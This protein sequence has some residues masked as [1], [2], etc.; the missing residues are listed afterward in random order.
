[1]SRNLATLIGFAAILLWAS[2][3]GLLKQVSAVLEPDLGITLVYT[4]ASILLLIIFRIP[5]LKLISKTY[6]IG[7]ASL[8]VIYELFFSFAIAYAQTDQQAIEVS[9][10]NYLW[11]S[12]TVLA[13]IIFKEMQF[14][15]FVIIG[16]LLS[17][18]GII[19]I[20][21]GNGSLNLNSILANFQSNPLSYILAF[22]GAI[23][24]SLYCVLTKKLG[25]GQNPIALFFVLATLVLWTKLLLHPV[26]FSISSIQISTLIYAVIA[27][28]AVG[29]GYASWNIGI[30]QGNITMLVVL[31]YFTPIISSVFAML[32]L[33]TD[34][35]ITF[36]QGTAMVTGGSLI[37]WL[38]TNWYS[39]IKLLKR[40]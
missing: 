15:F 25:G 39:L 1:M 38:S 32:I 14:N 31:S 10:V 36:W 16:L 19:F 27:A 12:L 2:M 28:L 22:V 18:S 26:A 21:A 37:C 13:F 23:L 24:W 4:L 11:P 35:P 7:G 5:N 20:Q 6:L 34:L 3:V 40:A 8:F 30:T 17:I 33:N 29:L 9:I